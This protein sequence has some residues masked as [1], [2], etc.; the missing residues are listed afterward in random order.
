MKA[1][2]KE[3]SDN[4]QAAID[5]SVDT[6]ALFGWIDHHI[7]LINESHILFLFLCNYIPV[8]LSVIFHLHI[9][10][11]RLVKQLLP[12]VYRLHQEIYT[13]V[14]RLRNSH[15]KSGN[16]RIVFHE[17]TLRLTTNVTV[18]ML[19]IRERVL[20]NHVMTCKIF[21]TQIH[22]TISVI[23]KILGLDLAYGFGSLLIFYIIYRGI[24]Q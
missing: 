15:F 6:C 7:S 3:H 19:I 14:W 2:L 16:N 11:T 4:S 23:F 17:K 22:T 13:A 18:L 21:L 12:F 1:L 24:I 5:S 10:S 20:S 9:N 8:P